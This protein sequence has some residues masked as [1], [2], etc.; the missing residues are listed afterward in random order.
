MFV[1][2]DRYKGRCNPTLFPVY[3]CGNIQYKTSSWTPSTTNDWNVNSFVSGLTKRSEELTGVRS[4]VT[5]VKF[6]SSFTENVDRIWEKN[7]ENI[8]AYNAWWSA[9][10]RF[11]CNKQ[12]LSRYH[13]FSRNQILR[14][15]FDI[16]FRAM[17]SP[18][19]KLR[20][21]RELAYNVHNCSSFQFSCAYSI[22][23]CIQSMSSLTWVLLSSALW[24]LSATPLQKHG[25]QPWGLSAC[26]LKNPVWQESQL[27]PWTLA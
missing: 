23:V 18:L 10:E 11:N 6:I 4:D 16:P 17:F 15:L 13:K 25:V 5:R 3:S 20:K 12:T 21:N 19:S 2:G 1:N 7:S 8:S 24:Q 26:R 22:A 9:V 27:T 14:K